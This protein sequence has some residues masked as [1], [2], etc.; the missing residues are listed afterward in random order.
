MSL[1]D[2]G[3]TLV[4]QEARALRSMGIGIDTEE[5]M[6]DGNFGLLR[7]VEKFDPERGEFKAFARHHI[8]GAM[9]DGVRKAAP[10]SLRMVRAGHTI[11]ERRHMLVLATEQACEQ[12][13]G[14]HLDDL[15]LLREVL[16]RGALP[17]REAT[18][19]RRHYIDGE[20]FDHIAR[21]WGLSKS[22][23]CRLHLRA[24][25]RLRDPSR[26]ARSP[27]PSRAARHPG[28]KKARPRAKQLF[29]TPV[30]IPPSAISSLIGVLLRVFRSRGGWTTFE[31]LRGAT[32]VADTHLTLALSAAVDRGQLQRDGLARRWRLP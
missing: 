27:Q 19:L 7:A 20:R 8:R 16:D 14:P 11:E 31:E 21:A 2:E 18:L 28:V 23:V 10:L 1:I 26:R 12:G 17:A 25:A 15:V 24:L 22:W 32:G 30:P 9:L 13:A 29:L 6:G 4:A 3:L 5:L